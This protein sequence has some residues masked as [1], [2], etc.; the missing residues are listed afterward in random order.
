MPAR[1]R[2][3]GPQTSEKIAAV[4]KEERDSLDWSRPRLSRELEAHGYTMSVATIMH[5]ETGFMKAGT[6]QR[7]LITVDE[8]AALIEVLGP[9]FARD[10]TAILSEG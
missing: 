6:R 5:I 3:I 8:L 10:V 9:G 2:E 4:L 7:R 1:F